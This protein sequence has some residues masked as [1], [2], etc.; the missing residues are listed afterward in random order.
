MELKDKVVVITGSS[1]GLGKTLAQK[2]IETDSRVV[3]SSRNS[4]DL[5]DVSKELGV[6]KFVAD[7]TKEEDIKNLA[8]FAVLK[9][10]RIDIWVNN[11]GIWIPHDTFENMD[12]KRVHDMVEVNLFGTI[13]GSKYA[14]LQMKKQQQGVI[15]NIISTSALTGRAGSSGYCASKYA[16]TGFTKSIQL[17]TSGTGIKIIAVY[18]GGMQTHLFDEKLPKDIDDYMEPSDVADKIIDNLKKPE[19]ELEMIIKK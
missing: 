9:F 3:I 11:A 17:E 19:P 12:L 13:Y 5:E 18:P 16:A 4:E 6:T 15:V 1:S 14:Y 8:E 10:G 7:V 2:F